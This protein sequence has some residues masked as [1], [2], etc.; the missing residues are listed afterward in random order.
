M[1]KP[2]PTYRQREVMQTLMA[3]EWMPHLKLT[4]AG[5]IMLATLTNTG[6]IE[7]RSDG[8]G[9]FHYR[10][11]ESGQVAFSSPIPIAR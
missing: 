8:C 7:R 3:G 4:P 5:D 6:W 1:T 2:Y 10:I 9:G 11:T